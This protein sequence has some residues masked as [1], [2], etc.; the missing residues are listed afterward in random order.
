MRALRTAGFAQT[1]GHTI[2]A[3]VSV[4][5]IAAKKVPF[6]IVGLGAR[7]HGDGILGNDFFVGHVVH[8]DFHDD[9]LEL[10]PHDRFVGPAGAYVLPVYYDGEALYATP[11]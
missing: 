8:L 10:I 3:D 4:G 11:F 1:L 2:V 7:Y 9:R 6:L 5:S